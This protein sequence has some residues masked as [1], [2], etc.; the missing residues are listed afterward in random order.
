MTQPQRGEGVDRR[1]GD[2]NR[3]VGG[4]AVWSAFRRH[5][6][7]QVGTAILVAFVLL[8][9][10]AEFL[11]PYTP[12]D[13]NSAYTYAPPT[14]LHFRDDGDF[15][16]LPFVYKTRSVVD[17]ETHARTFV[18][19]KTTRYDVRFFVRGEPYRLLG[20]FP[21]DVHL[22]GVRAEDGSADARILLFGADRF[23]R[24]LFTRTLIGSRVS[25]IVGPFV[26]LILLPIAAL[27]GGLS[28]YIGGTIDVVIQ[29]IGE[30]FMMIPGLPIVLVVGAALSGRGLSP[31]L[32]FLAVMGTLAIVGWARVARVVRGQVIALRETDFVTAAR[33]SGAGDLRIL[34]RH[35]LPHTTSYLVV[36]A[37]L[38]IP[39]TM[40]TEASLSFLGYGLREPLASWGSLLNA[41][42]DV[43]VIGQYPWMLIPAGFIIVSVCA[44]NFVGEGLRD[45]FDA[46]KRWRAGR[47]SR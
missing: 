34:L 6:L 44:F 11:S 14:R 39:G 4:G 35:V 43:T 28:G 25:L 12:S 2:K 27:A 16:L 38:L 9:A 36:T 24:D 40:L 23:G 10:F 32:T 5:R 31:I 33:A 20:L 7:A 30:G 3:R 18:E 19:D 15:R 42:A 45:A 41:A 22:F 1:T 37:T 47:A 17:P 29:R 21:T 46:T 26:I 13:Q 8:S